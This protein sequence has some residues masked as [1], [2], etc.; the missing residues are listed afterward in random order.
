MIE[1]VVIESVDQCCAPSA[2]GC[3]ELLS[4]NS[5]SVCTPTALHNYGINVAWGYVPA[6][7]YDKAVSNRRMRKRAQQ[8]NMAATVGVTIRVGLGQ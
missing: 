3:H 4:G 8:S 7:T 1:Q 5:G 6:L 2:D